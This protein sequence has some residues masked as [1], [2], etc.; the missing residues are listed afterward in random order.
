MENM[1]TGSVGR[2]TLNS[3]NLKM[4]DETN[5]VHACSST[6]DVCMHGNMCINI[7]TVGGLPMLPMHVLMFFPGLCLCSD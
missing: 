3:I 6:K 4:N 2:G 7:C 5:E 1:E